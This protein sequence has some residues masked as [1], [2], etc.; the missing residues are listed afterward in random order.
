MVPRESGVTIHPVQPISRKDRSSDRNPQRLY[1]G[2]RRS[3]REAEMRQSDLHG[4]M[5]EAFRPEPGCFASDIDGGVDRNVMNGP[6]VEL[7]P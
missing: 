4:D 7:L 1:A 2:L 6:K 3:T 5:Q